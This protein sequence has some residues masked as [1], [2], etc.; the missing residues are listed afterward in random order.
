VKLNLPVRV[1]GEK[2]HSTDSRNDDVPALMRRTKIVMQ[3]IVDKMTPE[4]GQEVQISC[5]YWR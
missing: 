5:C 3:K 2:S 4:N 1:H